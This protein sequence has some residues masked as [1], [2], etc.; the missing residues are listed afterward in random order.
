MVAGSEIGLWSLLMDRRFGFGGWGL[1]GLEVW[2]KKI[3]GGR[4]HNGGKKL[5]LWEVGCLEL[6]VCN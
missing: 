2:S 4:F 1:S 6:E 3:R 5:G